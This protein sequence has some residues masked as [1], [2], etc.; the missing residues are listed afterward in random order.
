MDLLSGR[1][2]D[3]VSKTVLVL[4]SLIEEAEQLLEASVRTRN[5]FLSIDTALNEMDSNVLD[6]QISIMSGHFKFLCT[7]ARMILRLIECARSLTEQCVAGLS[8]A[9]PKG[10]MPIALSEVINVICRIM[11]HIETF[12]QII[13]ASKLKFLWGCFKGKVFNHFQLIAS[14]KGVSSFIEELDVF[15]MENYFDVSSS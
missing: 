3:V 2:K 13:D 9:F 5:T 7:T 8:I 11:R 15:F 10:D 6:G 12:D 4:L 14:A 1:T